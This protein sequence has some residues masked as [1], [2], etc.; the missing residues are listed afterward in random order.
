MIDEPRESKHSKFADIFGSDALGLL[1]MRDASKTE[2]R[3][4]EWRLIESFSEISEFFEENKR[5][6]E[7][8]DDIGEYRLA[9]R[10][11]AIKS[12]PKKVK[13]LLQYDM[14]NML[15]LEE[16]KSVSLEDIL[17]DDP[18][19]LLT[20]DTEA[21]SIF[22]MTH[23]R[24]S[25]RLRPDYIAR[26]KVCKDFE[27]YKEAFAKI[28]N[29]LANG[30]RKLVEF[31]GQ[32]DLNEGQYYVL[33]GVVFYFEA[34]SARLT[35]KTY[36]GE[37]Y[38]RK[39]GRTRCIFDNGTEASMLFRSL[40]DAMRID[41]FCISDIQENSVVIPTVEPDDVQNGY[42]YVLR[43]LS[44]SAEVRSMHNLYK[45]GFC[46]ADVTNR[47]KNAIK[48][49]TYLMSEVEV[50]L[51]VRCYNL[52][53]LYLESNIHSFFGAVNV[54][55]EV[56]DDQGAIHQPR[57]WFTAP[58]DVIEETIRLI[59]D[60]EIEKYRYDHTLKMIIKRA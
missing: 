42:I 37:V 13:M 34:D 53:V 10:L 26:R 58:L 17:I 21:D 20:S 27:M 39:D 22:K 30:R 36:R 45:I 9:S 14:Y 25:E 28:H 56:K 3:T 11:A 60:R 16:T 18:F 33:R 7:L 46:S 12:D 32:E 54:K 15:K 41:G 44:R 35:E 6:P 48:E 4:E 2:H 23:V 57:E 49:P 51:T 52:N 47:I 55:F 19:R 31:K 43:S 59:V 38:R 29:A 5:P 1:D 40:V 24:S 50:I 8:S